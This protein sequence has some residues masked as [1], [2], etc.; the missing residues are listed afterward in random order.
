M[1][2]YLGGCGGMDELVSEDPRR[3]GPYQLEARLG[4]GG[5]G[6]VY[7]GRSP[8]GRHVA[9]KVIRPELAEDA[10]FRARFAR[11]V[12]AARQ[13]SGIFTASVVDA[14]L[15]GPVPWLATSY[16][17]GPSL[18]VMVAYHGPL[19]VASV[20]ALAAGLAEGLAAIHSSGVVH[21]DL[22]PANVLLA[23]DGPRLIDF[24][25]S[26]SLEAVALTRT[27]IV[28]GSPGF[29]S[30]EQADGREAGPPSDI[31]SLGA[32]LVFA[33]TGQ[34]PFGD[35][36]TPALLYR[37]VCT[38]PNTSG[39]PG[40]IRPVIERCLAKDP[41]SRPTAAQLLAELSTALPPA[42]PRA[43]PGP[44]LGPSAPYGADR[45]PALPTHLATERAA[46]SPASPAAWG[47]TASA[48]Q[49]ARLA[50]PTLPPVTG[51]PMPSTGPQL[52]RI[53]ASPLPPGYDR[54]VAPPPRRRRPFRPGQLVAI[55]AA[56]VLAAGAGAF[57]AAKAEH[58]GDHAR[59]A[60]ASS[61]AVNPTTP[62]TTGSS[63]ATQLPG[64]ATMAAIGSELTQSASVRPT[65]QPAIDGVRSCSDSPQSGETT[66][67]HAI[68]I[69]Q[70][71][72]TG[73]QTLSPSGLTSGA[74]L[75]STLETAMQDS[76]NADK[77]YQAWMTDFANAGNPCGS[78]PG[79]DSNYVAGQDASGAAT[80]AKDAFLAIW[81]PM[82]PR[83][84][85]Q[86]YT[87][88]DF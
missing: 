60:S 81:N 1:D 20:L 70:D 17:A 44:G 62:V 11:E 71:I 40:Q 14:D 6:R 18:A 79:Q 75:I 8:G 23:E 78:D 10:D 41:R 2:S 67:Q 73:L 52:P 27:G 32:V 13:V 47:P 42:L 12:A 16:V 19:P 76:I 36:T 68:S 46:P 5:M 29:M 43:G 64:A 50:G 7:L 85:Q 69:R 57:L 9:I 56:V 34:G 65:V 15:T 83:Y 74:Q 80:T 25:I 66:L 87:S 21:R 84:G 39:L 33:A 37:V 45:L 4:S 63:P 59:P 38:Q 26:R 22:K 49:Q 77:G 30:P 61:T 54:P 35:G 3:I 55:A 86:T 88:T 48:P 72:L 51:P 82:A 24:G 53:T 31:F 58:M 28:V